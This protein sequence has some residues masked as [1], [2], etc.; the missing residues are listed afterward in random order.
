MQ[1]IQ[2]VL[3]KSGAY[4]RRETGRMIEQKRVTVNGIPCTHSTE[5]LPEDVILIDGKPVPEPAERVYL[6]FHKP[7]GITCTAQKAVEGNLVDYLNWETRIF[8]VGRLDK[9]S[10]GLLILTNDGS[11]VNPLMK[12]EAAKEKEYIVQTKRPVSDS[13]IEK[14]CEGGLLIKGKEA[15]PAFAEKTGEFTFRIILKQGLNRQIRRMCSAFG[16]HVIS[17]K[18]T[19]ISH[20]HLDPLE[21]GEWRHLTTEEI[22]LLKEGIKGKS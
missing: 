5:V 20:I 17:L 15:S 22:Q 19:R 16:N 11:I 8:A 21:P 10:T 2:T 3:A 13:M 18:R 9:A 7:A 14:M 4:S 12:E 1:H 6:A